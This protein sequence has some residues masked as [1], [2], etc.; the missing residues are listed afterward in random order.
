MINKNSLAGLFALLLI[1][2]CSKEES[3]DATSTGSPKVYFNE[4]MECKFGPDMSDKNLTAMISE[5]QE[6]IT[7]DSLMGAWGYAPAS[8]SNTDGGSG[9][10]ELQWTSKENADAAWSDWV[11]NEEAIKWNEKYQGVMQCDGPGRYAFDGVFPIDPEA[12]GD[13]SEDG[14]FYSEFY[15][16]SYNEGS[17]RADVEEFTPGFVAAVA[18]S[19]YEET[20]YSYGNYFSNDEENPGFLWANFSA[21]KDMNDKANASFQADVEAKMFPLFSEFASCTETANVYHSWTLYIAG[22]EFM[23]TFST[24][25]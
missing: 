16:C 14:Y 7:D 1:V 11:E 20:R 23:P 21:S 2:S 9:W 19:N 15:S 3:D 4:F 5:W 24:M 13:T 22:K 18:D 25:E 12:Y 17:S 10:W 8:D 6:L